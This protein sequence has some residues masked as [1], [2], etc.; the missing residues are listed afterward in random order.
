MT[1]VEGDP[2]A[3]F[4]L[5]TTPRCWGWRYAFPGLLHFTLDAYI[6]MLSVMQVASSSIFWVFGMTRARV[7]PRSPGP[8]VNTQLIRLKEENKPRLSGVEGWKADVVRLCF[9]FFSIYFAFRK[10]N[11]LWL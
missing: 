7:E 3:L 11:A 6:I 1:L 10:K 9:L 8:L 2:K 4:S 5:G